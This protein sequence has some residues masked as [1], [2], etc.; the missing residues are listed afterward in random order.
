MHTG[1][2]APNLHIPAPPE[3]TKL[4]KLL[5]PCLSKHALSRAI[6]HGHVIALNT[7]QAAKTMS[8]CV[9][10]HGSSH[11]HVCHALCNV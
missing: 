8:S 11:A 1:I 2:V 7:T 10:S 3:T 9:L 6:L 4:H 5:T